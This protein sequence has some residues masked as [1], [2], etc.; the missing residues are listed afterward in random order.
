MYE[1]IIGSFSIILFQA[2]FQIVFIVRG[3]K[4]PVNVLYLCHLILML[5]KTVLDAY[6]YKTFNYIGQ[7]NW[8]KNLDNIIALPILFFYF[9]FLNKAV[10][11]HKHYSGI[12]KKWIFSKKKYFLIIPVIFIFILDLPSIYSI[13]INQVLVIFFFNYYFNFSC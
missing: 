4:S 10:F 13:I 2:L 11:V 6:D 8:F 12:G 1:I 9:D 3:G 5:L 7:P